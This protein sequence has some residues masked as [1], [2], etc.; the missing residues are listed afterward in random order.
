MNDGKKVEDYRFYSGEGPGVILARLK[1]QGH[2]NR[3]PIACSYTT[4]GKIRN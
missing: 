4:K 2:H 3:N 1:K